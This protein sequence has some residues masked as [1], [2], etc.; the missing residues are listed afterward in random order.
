MKIERLG[1]YKIGKKIGHGGMG[2]VYAALEV[3]TNNPAAIKVLAPQLA[4]HEG[5]R[6]RFEAEI[7]SLKKLEHPNIV[8]MFGY[9]QQDQYVYFAM[10]LVEGTSLEEELANGR[11]FQW[12]EVCQIGIDLCKALKLAHDHGIIH[13]DIKPANLLLTQ[14]EQ[15][16]L[17]DFGIAR[18]FGNVGV[19]SEGGVLG[20]AEYMA[21]EQADGRRVTHHCDLYSLGSV[22]FALLAGRAPFQANTMLEMLQMQRFTSPE[23]VRRYAADVPNEMERIISQLLEKQPENRFPNALMLGRRLEAMLH[24]LTIRK[25]TKAGDDDEIISNEIAI[26]EPSHDDGFVMGRETVQSDSGA[27]AAGSVDLI[28]A[29]QVTPESDSSGSEANFQKETRTSDIGSLTGPEPIP[30]NNTFTTVEEEKRAAELEI[31][32][33]H[34]VISLP[35]I[36]LMAALLVAAAALWLA[37]QPPSAD[38]LYANIS[39]AH[40]APDEQQLLDASADVTRFLHL[41]PDDYRVEWIRKIESRISVLRLERHASIQAR[42]LS[43]RFPNSLIATDY[44]AA[45]K[46]AGTDPNSAAEQLR[47]LIDLFDSPDHLEPEILEF[48]E[49]AKAQLPRIEMQIQ[50]VNSDKRVV[51]EKRL[52]HARKVAAEKPI[53]SRQICAAI[54]NLYKNKKWAATL[55]AEAEDILSGLADS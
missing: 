30:G 44:N 51:L 20:T 14:D 36:L 19:T 46:L 6:E 2:T 52:E 39:A 37:L 7:E 34:P 17:T 25:E 54:V 1:P 23:S 26:A 29:T 3:V 48:V 53:E 15:I 38:K 55:V 10:E 35:T 4:V 40:N 11:R 47:S 27:N 13:R 50:R 21:P 16:K 24:G 31:R 41:Y 45:I 43:K 12:R 22:M 9:G 5:F 32:K 42:L 8:K 33:A 49:A 18:L 28:A